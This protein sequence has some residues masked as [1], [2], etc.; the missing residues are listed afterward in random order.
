MAVDI[1]VFTDGEKQGTIPTALVEWNKKVGR[2]QKATQLDKLNALL[3][4]QLNS[5]KVKI[6]E[7]N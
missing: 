7:I 5:E 2:R 6:V 3:A 4:I 1:L